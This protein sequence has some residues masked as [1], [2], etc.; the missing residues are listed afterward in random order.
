MNKLINWFCDGK[1][2]LLLIIFVVFGAQSEEIN[3]YPVPE[4]VQRIEQFLANAEKNGFSGAVLVSYKGKVLLK[5]AFGYADQKA[6]I[7]ATTEMV[8]DTGSLTK[9]FTAA[10]ILQLVKE[11]KL[12]TED[13]LSKFFNN[14]PEDKKKI[15]LH[16]LLTHTSGISAYSSREG[17]FDNTETDEFFRKIFSRKLKFKPG[18]KHEYENVGYS[19]LGRVIELVSNEN[20]EAFLNRVFFKPLGMTQTGYLLPNWDSSLYPKAYFL[21]KKEGETDIPKYQKANRVSWMLKANG[22][23]YSTLPDMHKWM[24]ALANHQ[25]LT[26]ELIAL[27]IDKHVEMG[28][29]G[30]YFYGYGW[31]VSARE[32]A[33]WH[34]GS[35]AFFYS[36]IIWAQG[37]EPLQ[38]IMLSNMYF[39]NVTRMPGKIVNIWKNSEY[40][41]DKF[42]MSIWRPLAN[43]IWPVFELFI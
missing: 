34:N 23:I 31:A 40:S 30:N 42:K 33:V 14:L 6:K 37:D 24:S 9:Q 32:N 13:T 21:G 41:P 35:N 18:S 8:Y 2:M 17:D 7:P 22:G 5:D 3:N 38:V 39:K 11:S 16:Q 20:Y 25:I 15:T 1:S 43:L 10:G 36:H 29:S 28:S 12:S 4:R 26:K 19:I 27:L